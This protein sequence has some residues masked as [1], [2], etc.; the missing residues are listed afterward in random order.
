MFK[1]NVLLVP[2]LCFYKISVWTVS[3]KEMSYHLFYSAKR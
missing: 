3:E 1:V 2:F